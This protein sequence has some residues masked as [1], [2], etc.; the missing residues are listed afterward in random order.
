MLAFHMTGNFSKRLLIL[1]AGAETGLFVCL[2]FLASNLL[3]Y[4]YFTLGQVTKS[5]KVLYV[6]SR[7][8]SIKLQKY[9]IF[10]ITLSLSRTNVLYKASSFYWL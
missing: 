7:C 3:I 9:T 6:S 10:K 4:I 8:G 5:L 2:I 1:G